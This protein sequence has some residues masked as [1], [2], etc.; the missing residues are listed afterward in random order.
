MIL[1]FYICHTLAKKIGITQCLKGRY[2]NLKRCMQ[3]TRPTSE[4]E[5][6][7]EG[8]SDTEEEYEPVL[9]TPEE[10]TAAEHTEDKET[11]SEDSRWLTPVYTYGSIY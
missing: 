7:V 5:A 4:A 6:D 8:E 9:A 10:H 3:S 2:D 1:I 11:V